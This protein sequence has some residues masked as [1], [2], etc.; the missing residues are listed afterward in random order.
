MFC[1]E[2]IKEVY[3]GSEE[4]YD[5][6]NHKAFLDCYHGMAYYCTEGYRLVLV[7]ENY[8][9]SLSK[10]G[11]IREKREDLHEK[12]GEWLREGVEYTEDDELPWV[13]YETTL[14]VGER[15][16]SVTENDGKYVIQ[17]DDFSLKLIPC[18]TDD[19]VVGLWNKDTRSYNYVLGCDRHLKR[20][21]PHC[22][23]EGEILIDFVSD[24]MVRCKNCKKSTYAQMTLS[25]AIDEWNDGCGGCDSSDVTIEQE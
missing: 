22:G 1:D 3:I 8:A 21:C 20:S 17:F 24:Y 10:D 6:Y 16:L 12:E 14:F 4:Y 5:V 19:E 7:T 9:V 18:A 13:H 15:I 23:G 11:V 25:E 2:P